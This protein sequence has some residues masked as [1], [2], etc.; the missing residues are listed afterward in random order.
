MVDVPDSVPKIGK[1]YYFEGSG[2]EDDETIALCIKCIIGWA[3]SLELFVN[4]A[5]LKN[6]I[7]SQKEERDFSSTIAK[8]KCLYQIEGLLYGGQNGE[9]LLRNYLL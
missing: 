4:L 3:A 1:L 8:I 7:S 6:Q 2:L 9:V 5:W